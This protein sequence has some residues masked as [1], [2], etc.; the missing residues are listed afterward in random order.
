MEKTSV[1]AVIVK[2]ESGKINNKWT[3]RI[4]NPSDK[5]AFFIRPQVMAGEKEVLPS[6]W[7]ESYFTLAPYESITV[8]VTCPLA[9]LG[10]SV[11]SLKVSGW[12]VEEKRYF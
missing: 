5:I 1:D 2:T 4:T 7:S 3:V 12:N 6:F 9:S 8:T 11:R 10:N